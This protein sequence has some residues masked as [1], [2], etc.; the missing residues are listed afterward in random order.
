MFTPKFNINKKE[1]CLLILCL[2]LEISMS[3][4]FQ[5]TILNGRHNLTKLLA[6]HLLAHRAMFE[7]I[8]EYLAVARVLAH[9]IQHAI[10]LHHLINIK[11][12][13]L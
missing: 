10:T 2:Y 12:I 1:G 7:Y 8:V 5:V 4:L 9:Q 13:N 11:L 6:R 3:D